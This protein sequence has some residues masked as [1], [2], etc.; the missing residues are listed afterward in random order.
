MNFFFYCNLTLNYLHIIINKMKIPMLILIFLNKN[1][2]KNFFS[3]R[4]PTPP[5]GI[6]L[7]LMIYLNLH[8]NIL[9]GESNTQP[10]LSSEMPSSLYGGAVAGTGGAGRLR[11]LP[12]VWTTT[13]SGTA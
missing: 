2:G 1:F 10:S 3:A 11:R 13:V 9:I 7:L 5:I 12:P 4:L 6:L 8:L